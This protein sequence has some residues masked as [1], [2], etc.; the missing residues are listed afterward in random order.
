MQM[1]AR[2]HRVVHEQ[3]VEEEVEPVEEAQEA[4]QRE[5]RDAVGAEGQVVETLSNI[6]CQLKVGLAQEVI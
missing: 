3:E 5:E 1:R 4:T 6:K 2:V